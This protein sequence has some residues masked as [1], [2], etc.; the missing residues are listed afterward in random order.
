MVNVDGV[1]LGN[2]RTSIV[3]RDINRYFHRPDQYTEIEVVRAIAEKCKPLIFLDFHGH[4]AKKNA[5]MYGPN[6]SLD[7]KHY[8]TCRLLPKIISKLTDKFRYYSCS[9]KISQ[10]KINTSRSIMMKTVN[11][12][13]PFTIEGSSHGYGPRLEEKTFNAESFREVGS[14]IAESLSTFLQILLKLPKRLEMKE[15]K[16]KSKQ[17]KSPEKDEKMVEESKIK[18]NLLNFDRSVLESLE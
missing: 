11:V 2:F 1:V 6:Y 17:T 3:G 13:F 4:S 16:E 18:S 10:C 5:F 14:K 8:L 9:F 15:E 7:H 12:T